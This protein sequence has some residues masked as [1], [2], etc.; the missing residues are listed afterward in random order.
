[1]GFSEL[2]TE[3]RYGTLNERQ[4]RYVKHINTAASTFSP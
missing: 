2:L 1:M 3:E 4:Q